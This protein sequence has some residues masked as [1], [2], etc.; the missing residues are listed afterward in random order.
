MSIA[1]WWSVAIIVIVVVTDV[2][3]VI[4]AVSGITPAIRL[5]SSV[6]FH[7]GLLKLLVQGQLLIQPRQA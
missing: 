5:A 2:V 7:E 4:I 3:L 1:R 6:I